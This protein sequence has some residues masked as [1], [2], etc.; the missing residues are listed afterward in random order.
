MTERLS[1]AELETF[2]PSA[3]RSGTERRFLC[4]LCHGNRPRD[5]AHRTLGANVQTGAFRCHRCAVSG[6]LT[7]HQKTGKKPVRARAD[8]HR[9][10]SLSPET[11]PSAE[12]ESEGAKSYDFPAELARLVP[13]AGTPAAEYLKG[14]GIPAEL[15]AAAG[16]QFSPSFCGVPAVV[17]PILKDGQLV[18]LQ[19]RPIGE[20]IKRTLKQGSGPH[21]GTFATPG[22]LES[23]PKIIVEAPIDALSLAAAG[24]PAIATIGTSCPPNF[25]ERLPYARVLAAHD[26]D[27]AG[28]KA[29]K[30]LAEQ[31][32]KNGAKCDRLRPPERCKD[33]NDAL[34]AYGAEQLAAML[35]IGAYPKTC[36]APDPPLRPRMKGDF[37]P[38]D[39][40]ETSFIPSPHEYLDSPLYYELDETLRAADHAGN[41]ELRGLARAFDDATM[42]GQGAAWFTEFGPRFRELQML[43]FVNIQGDG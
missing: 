32:A 42:K 37:C 17:F 8:L 27:E 30:S 24:V 10:F 34:L 22:A 20:G 25:A 16:V 2:D 33:W 36:K 14:R 9:K 28:E 4:P 38:Q 35:P 3:R 40:T 18:A 31:L 11:K 7:E 6:L 23:D 21:G 5:A 29:S 19:G 1:L 15:A 43:T 12:Q 41:S 26:R 13:I 39:A